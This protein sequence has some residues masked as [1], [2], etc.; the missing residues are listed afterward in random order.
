MQLKTVLEAKNAIRTGQFM[1]LKN[2]YTQKS[3]VKAM[4]KTQSE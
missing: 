1:T 3:C 4:N 2:G